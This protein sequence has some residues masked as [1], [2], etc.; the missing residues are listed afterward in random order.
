MGSEFAILIP[1]SVKSSP[2]IAQSSYERWKQVFGKS[3]N[4][5]IFAK[6]IF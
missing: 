6:Y 3:C 2:K 4:M 1:F 5:R